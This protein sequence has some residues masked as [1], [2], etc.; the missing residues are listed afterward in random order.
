MELEVTQALRVIYILNVIS[1]RKLSIAEVVI[2]FYFTSYILE[3]FFLKILPN[4]KLQQII[5]FIREDAGG[6][7]YL[8]IRFHIVTT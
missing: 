4:N 8:F 1:I 5:T 3:W 6:F 7:L 2:N